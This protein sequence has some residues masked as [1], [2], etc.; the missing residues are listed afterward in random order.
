MITKNEIIT[1]NDLI[2]KFNSIEEQLELNRLRHGHQP[3]DIFISST[4]LDES[5]DRVLLCNGRS[6]G[7]EGVFYLDPNI[8]DPA[9]HKNTPFKDVFKQ[10]KWRENQYPDDNEYTSEYNL[11]KEL[12]ETFIPFIENTLNKTS[13]ET[14]YIYNEGIS[15]SI[16]ISYPPYS[17]EE[18][19]YYFSNFY[20]K[21][22]NFVET[23]ANGNNRFIRFASSKDQVGQTQ[24]DEI[25]NIAATFAG[26]GIEYTYAKPTGALTLSGKG[27]NQAGHGYGYDN[28]TLSFNANAGNSTTNPMAG[29]ASGSDIHPANI[30][31][32]IY[33]VY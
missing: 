27:D 33:L 16:N 9:P 5:T 8:T 26:R 30:A 19:N 1:A 25:R 11:S 31:L 6:F 20:F 10:L 2:E 18:E 28:A 17:A 32:P 4:W 29:H 12:L 3:G 15:G 23:A 21:L 7:L 14:G 13:S 22:P 24:I